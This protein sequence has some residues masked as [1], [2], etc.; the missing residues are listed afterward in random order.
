MFT[1]RAKEA[2]R[3]SSFD[4]PAE[5]WKCLWAIATVLHDLHFGDTNKSGKTISMTTSKLNPALILL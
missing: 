1:D 3:K 4:D 2:A 5:A